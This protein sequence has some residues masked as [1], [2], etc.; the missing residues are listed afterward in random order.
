MSFSTEERNLR[1]AMAI[2]AASGRFL[3]V[4]R[5]NDNQLRPRQKG[6]FHSVFSIDKDI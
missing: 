3:L 1:R 5:R 6:K 4:P 2:Q